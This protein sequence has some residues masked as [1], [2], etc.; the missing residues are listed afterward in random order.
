MSDFLFVMEKVK[1]MDLLKLNYTVVVLLNGATFFEIFKV[2]A[3]QYLTFLRFQFYKVLLWQG[4][5]LTDSRFYKV[6]V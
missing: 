2:L 3:L 1:Y 6:V 5:T 4:L